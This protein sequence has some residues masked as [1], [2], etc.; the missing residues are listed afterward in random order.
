VIFKREA[1]RSSAHK[2]ALLTLC[3]VSGA[4]VVSAQESMNNASISGRVTD[5]TGAVV[6][7]A[8]VSAR[9]AET[10]LTNTLLTDRDGRFR[11]PYLKVGPYEIQVRRQ[12][13]AVAAR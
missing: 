9:Q 12:G 1:R 6:D 3:A 10:N 5:Q 2:F 13:F 4:W 7:G 8:Q 11:F